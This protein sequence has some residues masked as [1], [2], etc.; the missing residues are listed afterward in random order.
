MDTLIPFLT[1]WGYWGMLVAAFLAGS[2]FPFSS[3][4]VMAGLIAANLNPWQLVVYGS[5]GN[6]AGSLFNYFLGRLG[7][8]EWI[9]KYLHVKKKDL[10]KAQKFMKGKGAWAGFFAFLPIIGSAI[11]IALGLM[12]ANLTISITSITLG[13]VLRYIILVASILSICSCNIE[14]SSRPVIAVT[15]EPMRYFTEQIVGDRYQVMTMVP[16][17]MSP[18]TYEPTPRQIVE[19]SHAEYYMKVGKIGFE[20]TWMRKLKQNAPGL[21]IVDTSKGITPIKDINGIEDPHT[22]MSCSSAKNIATQIY[23]TVARKSPKDSSFYKNNYLRLIKKINQVDTEIRA[24][25][26]KQPSGHTAFLIYHPT[27]TY[28]SRDYNFEQIPLEEEGK[29]PSASQTQVLIDRANKSD[30][31][32]IFVQKQFSPRK[33]I[34]IQEATNT[35]TTEINPLN[36]NWSDEMLKIAKSLTIKN[37]K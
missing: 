6:V 3:E 29:E 23:L 10:D 11:T 1:D 12:R 20:Q 36:Y 2:F 26:K 18:E 5:I 31:R 7:K 14:Q 21:V 30:I 16:S 9:E 13:K 19:L 35:G 15:I 22:W 8:M 34:T 32:T 17:G 24:M 27:L 37:R 4:A 25:L 33:T 28:F